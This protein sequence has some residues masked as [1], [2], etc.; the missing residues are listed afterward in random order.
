[1]LRWDARIVGVHAQNG[2][3]EN[4]VVEVRSGDVPPVFPTEP[5]LVRSLHP[6]E[7]IDVLL[8]RSI[9]ALGKIGAGKD[10]TGYARVSHLIPA[11][12]G[13]VVPIGERDRRMLVSD[14]YSIGHGRTDGGV[15]GPGKFLARRDLAAG[16]GSADE[17]RLDAVQ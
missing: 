12:I 7:A 6:S 9:A 11:G 15:P 10:R 4:G 1:M 2:A 16:K 3:R 14:G 13:E 17:L 5:E 8:D